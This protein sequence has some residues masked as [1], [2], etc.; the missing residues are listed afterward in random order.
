MKATTLTCITAIV[1]LLAHV[2]YGFGKKKQRGLDVSSFLN[3]F[4]DN[5][6]IA[7][8]TETPVV[9]TRKSRGR[10]KQTSEKSE[11]KC[12]CQERAARRLR[13]EIKNIA[14]QE[15]QYQ[16]RSRVSLGFFHKS[17][18]V[19]EKDHPSRYQNIKHM[20]IMC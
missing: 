13:R 16:G 4:G 18:V 15:C 11:Q 14:F 8:T 6:D 17:S 9:V 10:S 2:E 3:F 5:E 20:C 19:A 1:L 12:K 7:G